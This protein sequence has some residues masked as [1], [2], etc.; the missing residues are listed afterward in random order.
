MLAAAGTAFYPTELPGQGGP[1][2]ISTLTAL[3]SPAVPYGLSLPLLEMLFPLDLE[4][5]RLPPALTGCSFS[6]LVICSFSS[7]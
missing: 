4:I 7:P 3:A 1:L 2:S 5:C 6:T